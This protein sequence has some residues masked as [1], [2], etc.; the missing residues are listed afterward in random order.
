MKVYP[1]RNSETEMVL[2]YDELHLYRIKVESP[3]KR[4]QWLTALNVFTL[5][6]AEDLSISEFP[7]L[8]G[9]VYKKG[10]DYDWRGSDASICSGTNVDVFDDLSNRIERQCHKVI[11]GQLKMNEHLQDIKGK[12]GLKDG[13]EDG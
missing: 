8:N 13:E 11:M 12:Y 5:N 9:K 7:I 2:I 1:L 10:L 4:I 3:L 6:L